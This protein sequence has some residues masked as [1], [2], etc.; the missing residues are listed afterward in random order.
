MVWPSVS[1]VG[2]INYGLIVAASGSFT[3]RRSD[4]TPTNKDPLIGPEKPQKGEVNQV[5]S[6]HMSAVILYLLRGVLLMN[7]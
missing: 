7:I 4:L 2:E 1:W 3:G 6:I 5:C